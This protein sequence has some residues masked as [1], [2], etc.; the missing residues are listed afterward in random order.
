MIS[1]PSPAAAAAAAAELASVRLLSITY[2]RWSLFLNHSGGSSNNNNNNSVLLP[3]TSFGGDVQ[4]GPA[5][6]QTT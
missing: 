3:T 2:Q 1:R 5:V 4:S 6:G